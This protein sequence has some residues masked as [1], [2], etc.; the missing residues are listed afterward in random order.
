[1]WLACAYIILEDIFTRRSDVTLSAEDRAI[2]AEIM[3]EV[4]KGDHDVALATSFGYER[5]IVVKAKGTRTK[6]TT[7]FTWEPLIKRVK[8][9]EGPPIMW[10][11]FK[12]HFKVECDSYVLCKRVDPRVGRYPEPEEEEVETK[13]AAVVENDDESDDDQV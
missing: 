6:K 10:R 3:V 2:G 7:G 1:V 13:Q 11:A 12:Q 9:K 5:K 4:N 8:G